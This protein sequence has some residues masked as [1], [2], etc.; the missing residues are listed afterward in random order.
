MLKSAVSK[1][2][3]KESLDF[4]LSFSNMPK[5]SILLTDLVSTT[6]PLREMYI[7]LLGRTLVGMDMA[8]SNF[9][10]AARGELSRAQNDSGSY[11]Q[12]AHT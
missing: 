6:C 3:L 1:K 7:M 10:S 5:M 8:A 11:G 12:E 2:I 4:L 9:V